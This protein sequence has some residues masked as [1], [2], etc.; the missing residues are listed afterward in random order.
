MYV[1]TVKRGSE[2]LFCL[3]DR[4]NPD[5]DIYGANNYNRY[6]QY[7]MESKTRRQLRQHGGSSEPAA[8]PLSRGSYL[9]D[10]DLHNTTTD[11]GV[12]RVFSIL[13]ETGVYSR[14]RTF[15]ENTANANRM[16]LDH[17]HRDFI[18]DPE[19]LRPTLTVPNVLEAIEAVYKME[20]IEL[21][22]F[23]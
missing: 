14:S 12:E 19:L 18:L 9:P 10:D 23:R 20:G 6:L 17:N 4:D 1:E 13:V 21:E 22:Q 2:A 7:Q 11:A 15:D 3:Y 16:L 5:A 8:E